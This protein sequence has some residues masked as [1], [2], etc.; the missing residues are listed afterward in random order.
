MQDLTLTL[1]QSRLFWEDK[2]KNLAMFSRKLAELRAPGDLVI[3]PEMFNT[4][5]TMNAESLAET[6]DGPTV[7]WMQ[8]QAATLGCHIIG[9]LIVRE[10]QNYFNRLIWA[11]PD[12]QLGHYD[13]RHLFR[14]AGEEKVY[15]A[16]TE[17]LVV[18]VN[19]WKIAPF[20]CYDLRFPVWT[21]NL[22][23]HYDVSIYIANWPE[24]RRMHWCDLLK[25][26]AIE[27]LAYVVGVNRVGTDGK[28]HAHSG[29]SMVVSPK[30]QILFH[31]A[32]LEILQTLSLSWS[33]LVAYRESFPAWMD[34]DS[35]EIER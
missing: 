32:H 10:G 23:N 31:A 12:G 28:G 7:R 17:K 8:Q 33:D 14:M 15:S 30:G 25:A 16:G 9:S 13:K 26:R 21:R 22:G 29:D 4:G 34:A 24:S 18:E 6:M 11:H 20:I 2:E 3:L 5:F 1:V 35:F 19:G 27:N